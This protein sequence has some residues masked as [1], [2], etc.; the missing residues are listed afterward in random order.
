MRVYSFF[1]P[2]HSFSLSLYIPTGP[3]YEKETEVGMSHLYE[4]AIFR[5]INHLMNGRLYKELDSLGLTLSGATY[6]E[7]MQISIQGAPN[8]LEKA[9]EILLLALSPLSI[10]TQELSAE[11]ERIKRE[12]R[13][14][15]YRSSVDALS[16]KAVWEGTGLAETI[17]GN[18]GNVTKVT[19]SRLSD[20]GKE[21]FNK[22]NI[23]FYLTGCFEENQLDFL[24]KKLSQISFSSG[25][26]R[27]NIAAVPKRFF[28]RQ[29]DIVVKR[30]DYCKVKLAYDVDCQKTSK[31]ARDLVYDV[32]FQ[33][34]TSKIFLELSEKNGFVYSF[35]AN[36]DEYRNVGALSLSFE[37]SS[38]DFASALGLV[39]EIFE[40]ITKTITTEEL[41]L[42]KVP[43]TE[44]YAFILDDAENLNWNKAWES[45]ILNF[46]YET[47]E[48]RR[49]AYSRVSEEEAVK[50]AKAIFSPQNL[51]VSAKHKN[52]ETATRII[53][54]IFFS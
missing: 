30:A 46:G 35:D 54:E 31:P 23:F 40:G 15:S 20:F 7:L 9:I 44:N 1:T 5:N 24:L 43:Y 25:K 36:L 12:I 50:T 13:E 10:T 19:L 41:E 21:L 27:E 6:N 32:L 52:P 18:V 16:Q 11:K 14:D 39:K 4:H 22:E 45:H 38:A 2:V 33:G 49:D 26:R 42:A 51:T 53:K 37:T 34:D 48:E 29:P 3:L 28:N 17:T 47:L 8:H